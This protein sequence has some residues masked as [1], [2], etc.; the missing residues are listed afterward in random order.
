MPQRSGFPVRLIVSFV[1]LGFILLPTW[2]FAAEAGFINLDRSLIVQILNFLLL[3]FILWWFLYRPFVA[4]MEERTQA[5]KKSLEEAQA[6]RVEAQ[7]QQEE[8]RARLQAAHAEAQAIREAALKEA[9]DEQRRL[10]GAARQ[11]AARIVESGRAEIE[12]DVRRAKEE[13][14]RE[15]GELAIAVAER[16][17]GKSLREEDHRRIVKES[18]AQLE[19]IG[20][21]PRGHR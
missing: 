11:E 16:L 21:A 17:I 19:R 3:L 6:A 1:A 2:A 13:L 15:V 10:I 8:H 4:K 7:R 18:I 14:R 9:A 20:E 5:I 12:Q